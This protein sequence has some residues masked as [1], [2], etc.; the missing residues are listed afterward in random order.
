MDLDQENLTHFIEETSELAA[1]DKFSGA[2]LVVQSGEVVLLRAWNRS[3]ALSDRL[4]G[5]SR[6]RIG[7]LNKMFTA[8]AILQLSESGSLGLDDAIGTHLLD[9]PHR[10]VADRPTCA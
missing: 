8:V 10:G 6:F 1:E 9:Y 7:S 4:S 2:I 3:G 5:Q